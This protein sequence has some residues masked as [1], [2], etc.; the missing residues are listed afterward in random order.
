MND[1][2]LL[3]VRSRSLTQL[4]SLSGSMLDTGEHHL[5]G[6]PSQ[7]QPPHLHH[8]QQS[9]QLQHHPLGIEYNRIRFLAPNATPTEIANSSRRHK[10]SRSQ[11]SSYR[12][13]YSTNSSSI[14]HLGN[15]SRRAFTMLI[16][17]WNT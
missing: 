6:D 10:F 8:H 3:Q 17:Q 5:E 14:C 12:Q 4:D 15:D 9:H 2:L 7:Q 11:V 1:P 16:F 13:I